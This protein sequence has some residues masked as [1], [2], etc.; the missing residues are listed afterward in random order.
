M[1]VAVEFVLFCLASVGMTLIVV[2]GSIFRPL[3]DALVLRAEKIQQKREEKGLPPG[4]S[5]AVFFHGIFSCVQCAGF[6][7]GLFCGLFLLTSENFLPGS[8][9]SQKQILIFSF[10]RIIMLFCC[11]TAGSFLSMLGHFTLNWLFFS[12]LYFEQKAVAE[13]HQHEHQHEEAGQ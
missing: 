7:C 8:A 2:E 13:G 9:L 11:G 5:F 12:K 10:N 3:R 4:F 6:W 1:S